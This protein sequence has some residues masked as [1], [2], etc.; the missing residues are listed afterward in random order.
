MKR[1]LC[2]VLAVSMLIS[3]FAFQTVFAE[4]DIKVL[5]NGKNLTMDQPPVLVNDRTLVP[6]RA[7][8]ESLGAKVDWNNDT[9]TATGVLGDTT[10]EIQIENTIAKVNGKDVTLDVPAK[11]ISDRTLVPVRFISESLGAKV[12][13]DNDTQTVIITTEE[14]TTSKKWIFDDL[15]SFENNKDFIVGGNYKSEN[16]TLSTEQDHTTGSGK[17]VKLSNRKAT[18]DRLKIKDAFSAEDAGAKMTV[19]AY[20]YVPDVTTYISL[21]LYG[22]KGTDYAYDPGAYV[23]V[24]VMKNTWTKIELEYEHTNPV[25]TQIGIDQR[26]MGVE[27]APVIYV[28]D[29][30]IIKTGSSSQGENK[31][32]DVITNIGSDGKGKVANIPVKTSSDG[33]VRPDIYDGKNT[34]DDLMFYADRK[35][36]SSEKNDKTPDEIFASLSG[37]NVVVDNAKLMQYEVSGSK[38]GTVEKI[39][40]DGKE[41]I[42]AVVETLPEN[43]YTYQLTLPKMTEGKDFSDGDTMLLVFDMKTIKADNEM[44]MGKVQCIVEQDVDPFKKALSEYVQSEAGGGWTRVYLPFSAKKGFPRLCIR[45]GYYKQT[46]EIGDYNLYNFGTKYSVSDMPS[47]KMSVTYDDT[48]LFDKNASWRKEAWDRIERIRKGDIKVIV[49]DESGNLVK[50]ADVSVNMADHKFRFGSAVNTSVIKDSDYA[51]VYKSVTASLFNSAVLE[52]HH[53]WNEYEKKKD[54]TDKMVKAVKDMKIKYLRG[55]TLIWDRNVYDVKTGKYTENTSIPEELAKLMYTDE[56][57]MNE[58]IKNHIFDIV[59]R[60][61]GSICEWDVVNELVNN[62]AIRSKYGNK[63]L[64]DWFAWAREAAGKDVDLYI[65]ETGFHG[66]NND[67]Y[68]TFCSVLDYMTESGVDFN[69]IGVQGHFGSVV[70]PVNFYNQVKELGEKYNKKIEITEYDA[71]DPTM[72]DK[73]LEASFM[74]DIL[75]M[76]FSNESV[77]GFIMWGFNNKSHWKKFAPLFEE[78]W[79]LKE[80]GKQWLDLVYNK[81]WTNESGKTNESGEFNTRGFLGN[82][83][84]TVSANG[85]TQTVSSECFEKDGN[86]VTIVIK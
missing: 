83:D 76:C 53:K 29:V 34:Y 81:W 67:Q 51:N 66:T 1:I 28:D 18:S 6:V 41:V 43:A 36:E 78:D 72:T 55:H 75:I 16:I 9:N 25:I 58:M 44:S 45:L 77:E 7:I 79:T 84:I 32:G 11:L 37:G 74:R 60:Y 20:V 54:E 23:N 19:S 24:E 26:K 30:E 15:S 14:N 48:E 50:D 5:V 59:Q 57:K 52:S 82:Y 21:S 31:N 65:N 86:T 33:L 17:T 42:K 35:S 12:D 56:A 62:K 71:F 68:N 13:W 80:S 40:D 73:E 69:G 85:K 39:K 64:N 70:S 49:K 3:S 47:N 38:Y 22:D 46:I 2:L 4:N 63:V 61:K 10:I 27:V 8:F